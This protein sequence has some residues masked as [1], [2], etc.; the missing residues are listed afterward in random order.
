[1][2]LAYV[3]Y[4]KHLTELGIAVQG[5]TGML[6]GEHVPAGGIWLTKFLHTPSL[7]IAGGSDQVQA[8]IIAERVL[9]LPR[10]AR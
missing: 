7:R 5:A 9:G 10:D 8:N 4:M 3:R 6:A 1:M 2:K